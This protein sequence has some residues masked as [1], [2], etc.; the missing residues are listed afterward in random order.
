MLVDLPRIFLAYLEAPKSHIAKHIFGVLFNYI[1]IIFSIIPINSRS[2][3]HGGYYVLAQFF[4]PQG[5]TTGRG[6]KHTPHAL[7]PQRCRRMQ[8]PSVHDTS[9]DPKQGLIGQ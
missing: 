2:T 4:G 1:I 3:A 9:M 7:R 8:I 5:R 6:Q